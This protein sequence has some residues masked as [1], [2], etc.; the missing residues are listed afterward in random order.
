[1]RENEELEKEMKVDESPGSVV[2]P[3]SLK[4]KHLYFSPLL[5]SLFL[6]ML[7][8][9][10]FLLLSV[11]AFQFH[12]CF[13][14]SSIFPLSYF[15]PHALSTLSLSCVSTFTTSTGVT[16]GHKCKHTV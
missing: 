1:M 4:N 15:N 11:K 13:N 10:V 14:V 2:L 3:S 6:R 5:L 12:M 16:H 7:I 9:D 8:V